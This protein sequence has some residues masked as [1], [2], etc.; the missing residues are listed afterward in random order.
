[1]RG[2]SGSRGNG[3][4][5][6]SRASGITPPA[7][8]PALQAFG[9]DRVSDALRIIATARPLPGGAADAIDAAGDSHIA[10]CAVICPCG[11]EMLE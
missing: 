11:P 7:I 4:D 2:T 1:M 9:L 6:G 8:V 3:I 5:G 10:E